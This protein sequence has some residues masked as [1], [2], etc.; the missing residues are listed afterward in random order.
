MS[1][2]WLVPALLVLV[3]LVT[4]WIALRGHAPL[5]T[6]RDDLHAAIRGDVQQL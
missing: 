5:Q 1:F 6:L 3:L 2:E 4:L